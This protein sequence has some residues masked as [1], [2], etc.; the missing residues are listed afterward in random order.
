[1][2]CEDLLCKLMFRALLVAQ[3]CDISDDLTSVLTSIRQS[4]LREGE[5]LPCFRY[6]ITISPPLVSEIKDISS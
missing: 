4:E 1:M 2:Q 6:Y 5:N 3:C